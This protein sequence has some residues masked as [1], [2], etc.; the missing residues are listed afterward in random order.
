M[1]CNVEVNIDIIFY[2]KTGGTDTTNCRKYTSACGTIDY[3]MRNIVNVTIESVIYIDSGT[4]NY[5]VIGVEN[6]EIGG[7]FN[8]VF[9]VIGYILGHVN[10][11]DSNTYPVIISNSSNTGNYSFYLYGNVSA[12][13]Q[14]LKFIVGSNSVENR[15]LIVSLYFYFILFYLFIYFFLFFFILFYLFIFL[16]FFIYFY[17]FFF[18]FS[19]IIYLNY[20]F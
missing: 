4:Y 8:R 19:L 2:L 20:R 10:S 3:V 1:I 14:Y 9:N 11:Y 16:F 5:S 18:I 13:F 12:C 6:S 15:G 7:Y 17:L